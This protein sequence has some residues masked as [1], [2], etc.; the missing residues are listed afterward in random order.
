MTVGVATTT[1]HAF[2]GAGT[3]G[4]TARC[5]PARINALGGERATRGPVHA[6]VIIALQELTA[7]LSPARHCS[8]V[9]KKLRDWEERRV[10][11]AREIHSFAKSSAYST[12]PMAGRVRMECLRHQ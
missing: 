12:K 10:R 6:R 3:L 7:R 11:R 9:D 1:V 2:A 8:L 5:A 4:L